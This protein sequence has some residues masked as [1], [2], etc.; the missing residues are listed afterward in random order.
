MQVCDLTLMPISFCSNN[1]IV[2]G[3]DNTNLPKIFVIIADGVANE[4][5][6]GED[7]CSKRMANVIR[8]VQV[9]FMSFNM[10]KLLYYMQAC[11]FLLVHLCEYQC[12]YYVGTYRLLKMDLMISNYLTI[13]HALF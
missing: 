11:K 12:L 6:K 9:G 5:I 8:Q 13:L 7:G 3:P 4:S 2:L 1:P 10:N